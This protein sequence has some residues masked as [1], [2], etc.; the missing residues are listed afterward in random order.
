MW[1]VQ[2]LNIILKFILIELAILALIGIVFYYQFDNAKSEFVT[3][4][5]AVA[6]TIGDQARTFYEDIGKEPTGGEFYSFLDQRLGRKKL[7]NAFEIS[8]KFF[9]VVFKKDVEK[10]SVAGYFMKDF[11]PEEGYSVKKQDGMI[12]VLVPFA[13]E[14]HKVPFGIVR[15]NS[16]T[17]TL[18]KKVFSDN[19]LLYAAMIIVLNNQAL[20]L[21]LFSRRKKEVLIDKGYLKE[22]SVGALKIMHKVLGDIIEDH[23]AS[24]K[25]LSEANLKKDQELTKNVISISNLASK[26]DK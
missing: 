17:K 16:D 20:I 22:H 24:D 21:Y 12:S 14:Q 15:I 18:I 26:R 4:T 3:K 8:P 23:P 7:F 9:S 19:F 2:R 25:K 5:R 11:Y 6:E 13:T 1:L 10:G